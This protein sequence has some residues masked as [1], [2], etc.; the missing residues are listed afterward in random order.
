MG[1]YPSGIELRLS[2][3]TVGSLRIASKASIE[4]LCA[5]MSVSP[6]DRMHTR[7]EKENWLDPN[8]RTSWNFS[9]GNGIQNSWCWAFRTL[10]PGT[11]IFHLG[12]KSNGS[13][14]SCAVCEAVPPAWHKLCLFSLY[15]LPQNR[16]SDL[17]KFWCSCEVFSSSSVWKLMN[18]SPLKSLPQDQPCADSE[19][20]NACVLLYSE[21]WFKQHQGLK[22]R[23]RKADFSLTYSCRQ[24]VICW[25]RKSSAVIEMLIIH[26]P[27]I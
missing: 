6:G 15:L 7:C 10:E 5:A 1:E 20:E 19:L 9:F 14:C 22:L 17:G 26:F 23:G 16:A 27:S 24:R 18:A 8:P 11:S 4:F 25:R 3:L 2:D 12:G 13:L 21:V